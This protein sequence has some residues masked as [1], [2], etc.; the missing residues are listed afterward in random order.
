MAQF[1]VSDQSRSMIRS[2]MQRGASWDV[3]SHMKSEPLIFTLVGGIRGE[4]RFI[5]CVL[6]SI[7][8]QD[9]L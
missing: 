7:V 5:G 6:I 1:G 9:E 8:D 4:I 2:T 3:Q